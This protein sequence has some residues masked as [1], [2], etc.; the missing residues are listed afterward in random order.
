M[1][2]SLR[3]RLSL[4]ICALLTAAVLASAV[5]FIFF[6]RDQLL[7]ERENCLLLAKQFA[8]TLNHVIANSAEPQNTLREF[9]GN[10]DRLSP[11]MV[12]YVPADTPMAMDMTPPVVKGVPAWFTNMI[13]VLSPGADE[14][15]PI[16]LHGKRIGDFVVMPD[17]SADI[18]EKWVT[19]I[20]IVSSAV[21]L[22][23]LTSMVVYFTVGM[24]LT[25]IYQLS[26][27]LASLRDGHYETRIPPA[28]PPEFHL[29]VMSLN[30]LADTLSQLHE[31]NRTLLRRIVSIQDEERNELSRELHDEIGPLLFA[32]RANAGAI[33][34]GL[35]DQQNPEA[36]VRLLDAALSLQKVHRSI[37]ER[38]RPMH[39]K[40]LGLV[41]SIKSLIRDADQISSLT[42]TLAI[43]PSIETVDET[44]G[45]T[46][47][48]VIQEAL[49]N[50]MRHSHATHIDLAISAT[51]KGI[52]I[53]FSDDGV[54]FTDPPRM[55]RGLTGMRERLRALGGTLS[56]GREQNQ[57]VL[58]SL[59]PTL[60]LA[61]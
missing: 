7:D 24:S 44:T 26:E 50:V 48:R 25:P 45:R 43:D 14:Q 59:L 19:F 1:S 16:L 53:R 54:G 27:G 5:A 8:A 18:H 36:L 42:H 9:V 31:Q 4:A 22:A 34:D 33:K 39:L 49:T 37:L 23:L 21:V 40:E 58:R 61:S 55:G 6:S 30:E 13:A 32:V 29:S 12:G 46:I 17:P 60:P 56:I 35:S 28:G 2:L 15:F 41:E 20:G 52:S 11:G 3:S 10:M 38:L 47:Y 57:T 51:S